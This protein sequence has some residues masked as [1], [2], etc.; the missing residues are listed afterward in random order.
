MN[1]EIDVNVILNIFVSQNKTA[2]A[3]QPVLSVSSFSVSAC[4]YTLVVRPDHSLP[5]V[6][7]VPLEIVAQP[8]IAS[9]M[10]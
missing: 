2:A 8:E 9:I 10:Y 1:D 6:S 3:V 4:C 5:Q 7:L